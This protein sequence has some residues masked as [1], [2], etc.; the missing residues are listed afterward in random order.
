MI[1]Y[2]LKHIIECKNIL[3]MQNYSAIFITQSL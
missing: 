1:K 2:V 3:I